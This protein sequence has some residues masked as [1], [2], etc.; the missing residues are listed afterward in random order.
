[1]KDTNKINALLQLAA[2]VL[3]IALNAAANILPINGYNTG[4]ISAMF[5]NYF[6]PAGFTFAIWSFLYLLQTFWVLLCLKV[7]FKKEDDLSLVSL[8]SLLMPYFSLAC[9]LN[10]AWILCW[11]FLMIGGSLVIMIVLLIVLIALY[12]QLRAFTVTPEGWVSWVI[13]IVFVTYLAWICVAIIAN[14]TAYLVRLGM[15]DFIISGP[16]W[17]VIMILV[18]LFLSLWIGGKKKES[19]FAFVLAWAFLGIYQGQLPE[20]VMVGYTALGAS[21]ISFYIGVYAAVN[22]ARASAIDGVL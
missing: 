16:L 22:K 8:V 10:G 21:V 3:M 12:Y 4:E 1:V 11:H 13:P 7:A 5:P 17:S 14:A 20:S 2:F 15:N 19:A 18:A 6:V 9:L